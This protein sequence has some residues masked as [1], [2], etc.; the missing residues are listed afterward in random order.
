V[1]LVPAFL[2]TV[3]SKGAKNCQQTMHG[4]SISSQDICLG[5]SSNALHRQVFR[6]EFHTF[7]VAK[8]KI[9]ILLSVRVSKT[10]N[11]LEVSPPFF[12]VSEQLFVCG[13]GRK[14]L[15]VQVLPGNTETLT[16]LGFGQPMYHFQIPVPHISFSADLANEAV[17]V[18]LNKR[19]RFQI[20][21]SRTSG[22]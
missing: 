10:V 14:N 17:N 12:G 9:N 21:S 7:G 19:T 20:Y 15:F 16:G 22:P 13:I 6:A 11:L 2:R 1:S 4:I 5:L 3:G 18:S 8:P